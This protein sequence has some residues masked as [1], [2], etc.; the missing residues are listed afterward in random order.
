MEIDGEGG[1]VQ[2]LRSLIQ[3]ISAATSHVTVVSTCQRVSDIT[4]STLQ[5]SCNLHV[6]YCPVISS[7]SCFNLLMLQVHT[8]VLLV[9][10]S[11]V[12]E[13]LE[14]RVDLLT[15]MDNHNS[16]SGS[17]RGSVA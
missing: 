17:S 11:Q 10:W 4:S 13:L 6:S 8:L 1:I 7:T 15:A 3:V 16:N 12:V 14:G 2:L 9:A 5:Y